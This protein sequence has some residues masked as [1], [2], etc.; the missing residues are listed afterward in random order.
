MCRRVFLH[1]AERRFTRADDA[2]IEHQ[3]GRLLR[4]PSLK[5]PTSGELTLEIG[6]GEH[7][8]RSPPASVRRSSTIFLNEYRITPCSR[9]R[10][11]LIMPCGGMKT[12]TGTFDVLV[13]PPVLQP[14]ISRVRNLDF[15]CAR[16]PRRR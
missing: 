9:R 10:P 1:P 8:M 15:V 6:E 12:T 3:S 4:R 5:E 13:P 11:S 7:E 14:R 2:C 16:T